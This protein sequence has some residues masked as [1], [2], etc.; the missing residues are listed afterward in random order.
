MGDCNFIA[1]K[2]FQAAFMLLCTWD[3][4]TKKMGKIMKVYFFWSALFNFAV[5]SP[6]MLSFLSVHSLVISRSI[7]LSP[8]N[9][10]KITKL[11]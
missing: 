3:F 7:K 6:I 9:K 8:I 1:I 2:R 5:C 4:K 10:I 11:V